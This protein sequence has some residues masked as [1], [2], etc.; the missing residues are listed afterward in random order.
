MDSLSVSTKTQ[1]LNAARI[2]YVIK[3]N[4]SFFVIKK[5]HLAHA[6]VELALGRADLVVGLEVVGNVD[7]EIAAVLVV[8]LHDDA[9]LDLLAV[10]DGQDVLEIEDGLFPVG[11][12]GV[13]AGREADGLVAGG[14][15]NVEPRDKGVDKVVALDVEGELLA[16]GQV[17]NGASVQVQGQDGR[18]V[19]DDGLDVDG[20]D[21]GL[22]EGSLLEGGVVEAVDVIPDYSTRVSTNQN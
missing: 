10:L 3:E 16:E 4:F 2:R 13:R 15:V 20:V 11:V 5:H 22:G 21:E 8:G 14:E 7:V 19:G 12:L 17:G 9:A 18:G 1:A 6:V